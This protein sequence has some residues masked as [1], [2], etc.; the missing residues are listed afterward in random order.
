MV[1]AHLLD[2]LRL[3]RGMRERIHFR[4]ERLS[5][6]D[7]VVPQPTD[8]DDTDLLAGAAAVA[9]EGRENGEAGAEHRGGVFGG[10]TGGDGEY[11]LLVCADRGG[12]SGGDEVG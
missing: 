9:L 8:P 11:E 3:V 4:A 6:H 2:I 10:E 7:G 1:R 5:E 12:E